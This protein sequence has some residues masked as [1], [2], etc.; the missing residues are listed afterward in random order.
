MIVANPS[1]GPG[2]ATWL[3]DRQQSY[4]FS[5]YY[6]EGAEVIRKFVQIRAAD[7]V[8]DEMPNGIV[9]NDGILEALNLFRKMQLE[10]VND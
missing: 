3:S 8:F 2:M 5:F 7:Q 1:N 9:K 6:M 4:L 10:G